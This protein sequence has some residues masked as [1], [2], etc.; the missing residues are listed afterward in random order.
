M[1]N[2]K[3]Q[4]YASIAVSR[5]ELLG[6]ARW[7]SRT[8]YLHGKPIISYLLRHGQEVKAI[9]RLWHGRAQTMH[10]LNGDIL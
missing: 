4:Y 10:D 2:P 7:H 8:P 9:A 1:D 6:S 3:T 5:E